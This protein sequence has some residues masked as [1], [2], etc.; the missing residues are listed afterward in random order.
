MDTLFNTKS[1]FVN[2]NQV[3]L[4]VIIMFG[5]PTDHHANICRNTLKEAS[6]GEQL[7]EHARDCALHAASKAERGV[8]S[9]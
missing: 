8:R 9:G 3:F 1:V 6:V 2:R 5:A 7:K 4:T